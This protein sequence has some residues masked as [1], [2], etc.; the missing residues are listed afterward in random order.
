MNDILSQNLEAI[1]QKAPESAKILKEYS[2][3]TAEQ[4]EF[5]KT[6]DGNFSV[7]RGGLALHSLYSPQKEAKTN[8]VNFLTT[9]KNQAN[10]FVLGAALFYHV[11]E[12]L[13]NYAN[14]YVYE[15]DIDLLIAYLSVQKLDKILSKIYLIV[16]SSSVAIVERIKNEKIIFDNNFEI[17][18]HKPSLRLTHDDYLNFENLIK[19]SFFDTEIKLKIL[20]VGPVYGGSLPIFNYC[21]IALEKLGHKVVTLDNSVYKTAMDALEEVSTN[22]IHNKRSMSNFTKLLA[23][24]ILAKALDN[25]VNL[26]FGIAQS[27]FTPQILTELKKHNIPTA[28]WFVEDYRTLTYWKHLAPFFDYF[29]TIQKKDFFEELKQIGC[30]KYH[31]LP[32]A[33]SPEIHKQ[34]KL[35]QEDIEEFGSDLSF[36][37]AGYYNRR[38]VFLSLLDRDFKIWGDGWNINS[39]LKKVIQR[40]GSRI[41]TEEMMKVFN[42]SLININLHSSSYVEDVNPNGDFL[43]P[44][45]FELAASKSFQL[46]DRRKLL[47]ELFADDEIATFTTV[48]ELKEKVEYFLNHPEE[49]QK[50]IEKGYNRVIS[51]HSYENRMKEMINL[52]VSNDLRLQ[53]IQEDQFNRESLLNEAR[54]SG[55]KELVNIL[56]A[57]EGEEITLAGVME[58]IQ[59]E[60]CDLSKEKSIFVLMNEFY[61]FAKRKNM[62]K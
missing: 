29:F 58:S 26:V 6:K 17:Y 37:G 14:I 53:N 11:D 38:R 3:N 59:K 33:C 55:N 40:E 21:L 5:I 39:H 52:V 46:V 35:S 25:N 24:N 7:K 10:I 50:Y 36:V 51:D 43:N 49:R 16:P 32:N 30:K 34:F 12:L 8:I 15:S 31:Y 45:T 60:E 62:V 18:K 19:S 20:L 13:D 22:P 27:P 48:D 47:A 57:V 42:A 44:R 4:I 61:K 56:S 23:D 54:L 28:F 1:S 2:Q 9:S 41:T